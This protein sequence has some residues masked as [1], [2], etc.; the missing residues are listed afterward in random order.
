MHDQTAAKTESIA[1]LLGQSPTVKVWVDEG[2]RG[3]PARSSS[4]SASPRRPGRDAAA[5][6]AELVAAD[7]RARIQQ[8]WQRIRVEHAIAEYK[9]WRTLQRWLGHREHF[10]EAYLAVGGLVLD[11]AARR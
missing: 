10:G 6:L 1:D 3:W 2:Y 5:A 11:R 9:Q 8:S 7:R 4:R